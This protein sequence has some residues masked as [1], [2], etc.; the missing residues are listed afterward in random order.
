M[1]IIPAIYP[2]SF[3]EVVDKLY[4]LIDITHF[5]QLV[6]CDGSYGLRVSWSPNGKEILPEC[7]DYEADL[8]LTEWKEYLVKIS[9]MGIRSIVIHVD[10]FTDADYDELFK[11]V[12]YKKIRLGITVSND[13]SVDVMLNAINKAKASG[14]FDNPNDIFLQVTGTRSFVNNKLTFDERVL[15]RIRVLKSLLPLHVIQVSGRITPETSGDLKIAGAERLVVSS[16]IFGQE[17]LNEAID[18]L[19]KA[20]EREDKD[21]QFI[22]EDFTS[23]KDGEEIYPEKDK[24][25]KDVLAS[26]EASTDRIIYESTDDF[27][28][29]K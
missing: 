6:F 5:V 13:I 24:Q 1:K 14:C 17:N 20:S 23:K 25:K 29:E 15:N 10:E 7:F 4:Q 26:Y 3:E 28:N 11:F 22:K 18:T 2:E 27:F 16:Y 9:R 21:T 19:L 12:Y 8:I